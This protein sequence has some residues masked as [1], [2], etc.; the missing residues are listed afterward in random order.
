MGDSLTDVTAPEPIDRGEQSAISP[1]TLAEVGRLLDR[2]YDPS[3]A[4]AWDAVGTVTGHPEQ[5]VAKIMFAVDP[6]QAVIDEAVEWRADLLVVHHPLLLRPVQSVGA[7]SPK[8]R[9]VHDLISNGV[10]L[11]VCHT[12]A[13]SP[14]AGVSEA[15]ALTLGL[16]DSGPLVAADRSPLDKIVTFVPHEHTQR[17]IDALAQAGA[18]AIGEYDRCAFTATGLGTFRPGPAADPTIGAAGEIS[19]VDETRLEMVLPRNSRLRVVEAL[20]SAH[21]YEEPAFDV[22]ELAPLPTERGSG[23]IG[24]LAAEQT[25]RHFAE[26]VAGVLPATAQ[27]V[28]VAGDEGRMIRTVAVVGGAGDSL[29]AEVRAAGPDVYL[30][31]D[32]RH[33]PASEFREHPEAPALIDVSHWA[34][35]WTWLPV[36]ERALTQELYRRDVTVETHVSRI[37]TDPWT[38]RVDH[39]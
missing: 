34:A 23:R 5:P 30:T 33:H 32:L 4:D 7:I 28:R 12:N 29:L 20:R 2:L 9:V 36:V 8:G 1:P 19:Q 35:E 22:F 31:S 37:P 21:P 15:L 14:T 17:I 16:R 26:H 3:W 11:H 6:V 25:L 27:G 10:A 24:R 38:F 18:G 39:R 13:D